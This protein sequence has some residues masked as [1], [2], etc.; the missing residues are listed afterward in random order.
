MAATNQARTFLDPRERAVL[1]RAFTLPRA[2]TGVILAIAGALTVWSA[3][4]TEVSLSGL[5]HGVPLFINFFRDLWPPETEDLAHM[6]EPIRVTLQM[7]IVGLLL[8]MVM[9]FPAG[10]LAARNTSPHPVVYNAARMVLNVVRA[11]PSLVWAIIVVASIGFGPFSGVLALAIAGL[12]TLGKLYSEAIEA[13]NPRP[14]EAL[15]A[16][17]AGPV[18]VFSF[19]V[20]PQAMPLMVSYTLL[21][22][23]SNV[24]SATIL[25]IVGAGGIGFELQAAFSQFRFHEVLTILIEIVIL[26]ALIDRLSSMVRSRLI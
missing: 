25:G 3:S 8:S 26:V 21:D 17:G 10:L 16:T 12:G 19:A 4:G 23:E 24:R 20:L 22:F 6:W 9:A 2:R 11:I 5:L 15:T 14:V 18:Q 7:S 13:I 1:R